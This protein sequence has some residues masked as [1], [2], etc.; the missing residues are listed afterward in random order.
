MKSSKQKKDLLLDIQNISIE[1]FSDEIWHP[2]IKGVNLQLYR[3]EVLGLI[4]ESGAGKSTL[5]LAAMGFVRTGCR[6]TSGSI[7]FNGKDLTKLSDKKKQQ[8]WGTKLSYVAQSAAAAFNPA[9]RLINQTIESSLSH[10]LNIKETLQ[11]EAVQLYKEMQL[12]NPDEI[13]E[14]YPH[15]VSGGQ[16]QRTMTAMA[17]SSKPDLIIF[18]EPTTALDVTTQVNVLATIRSIVKEHQTAA[19]YITHDLAVVAQ[20]ADRIQVLRYGNTVEVAKTSQML[21]SPKE[22]YTK[23]LWAVRSIKKK[24]QKSKEI[25]LSI[26]NVSASYGS[27]PKVLQDI[28]INVPTGRT[29]AIVGESGSGKSTTARAITGLLPPTQGKII[30]QNRILPMKLSDRTK[31]DLRK[32]QMIYQSPDTSMN[33]RHTVREIIGRPLSFYHGINKEKN[34]DKVLELLNMIELDDSFVD[35]LPPRGVIWWSKTKNLYS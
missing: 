17:M 24:E 16:L 33:P 26:E 5:G 22:E 9:H 18:D 29:V 31:E 28:N 2:I 8:L 25:I 13:G 6:F 27:G 10:K 14:R 30:F 11:K 1:G 19:I 34:T 21:K 20:M 7:N 15:Q 3:G 12:P 35:R 4:G 23:S 32:I